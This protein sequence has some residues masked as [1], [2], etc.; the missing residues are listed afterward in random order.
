MVNE[1]Y[2]AAPTDA[3]PTLAQLVGAALPRLP[4]ALVDDQ[5]FER[6]ARGAALFPPL[7]AIG[8]ECGL[9][10]ADRGADL[11][12]R[13]MAADGGRELFSRRPLP[14]AARFTD[15]IWRGVH[16]FFQHW[17]D[18]GSRLHHEVETVWL[19]FD[20]STL[21]DPVPR[22]CVFF[23]T[24]KLNPTSAGWITDVAV[25]LLRRA[26]LPDPIRRNVQRCIGA[27][28]PGAALTYV[29]VLLSRATDTIRLCAR[30]QVERV[31][32][33]LDALEWHDRTSRLQSVL[34]HAARAYASDVVVNLDVGH[35]ISPKLGIEVK[36]NP[37]HLWPLFLERL[38]ALGLC[39]PVRGKAALA[40][41]GHD[42]AL[43]RI[44]PGSISLL[45][46]ADP[47]RAQALQVRTINHA[48]IVVCPEQAT[49][50]KLYL[51][52][53]FVWQP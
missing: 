42:S 27:L 17:A 9:T 3:G 18:E 33:Y 26:P 53:G 1:R 41:P 8:I 49:R 23:S 52:A 24:P 6:I 43:S 13:T 21:G 20:R 5:A 37:S 4:I 16:S 30:M 46:P 34:F 47:S 45:P 50:A 10:G 11:S 31:R 25:D 7:S 28:P 38:V 29:G 48:K 32:P 36:P 40:W 39:S 19:E 15:P 44:S 51:Y 2:L 14:G 35:S 22:P 12:I